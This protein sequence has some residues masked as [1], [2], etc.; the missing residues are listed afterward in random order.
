VNPDGL[1][2]WYPD[3]CVLEV[4]HVGSLMSEEEASRLRA[5]IE[6]KLVAAPAS[7]IR[8]IMDWTNAIPQH[9][10]VQAIIGGLG[11]VIARHGS[12]ETFISVSPTKLVARI[13]SQRLL[14][15]GAAEIRRSHMKQAKDVFVT[16][17]DEAW[18]C[19]GAT[20]PQVAGRSDET[21]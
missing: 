19:L 14:D 12:C 8:V 5:A 20:R 15:E 1:V 16:T 11:A 4:S 6:R 17:I 21:P 9:A 7:G 2:V 18:E 10:P 3:E 13:Q